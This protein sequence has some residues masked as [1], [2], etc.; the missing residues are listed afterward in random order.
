MSSQNG[1]SKK[2]VKKVMKHLDEDDKDF[3]GQIK[4]DKKLKKQLR[5]SVKEKK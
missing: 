4:S 3:R 2:I 1:K 5:K